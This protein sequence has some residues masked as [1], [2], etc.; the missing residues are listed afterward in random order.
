MS[1]MKYDAA[2]T[3]TRNVRGAPT[4]TP[5]EMAA[6]LAAM[7]GKAPWPPPSAQTGAIAVIAGDVAKLA[8]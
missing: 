1:K 4:P 5:A 3:P 2:W 8:S 7:A 6:T